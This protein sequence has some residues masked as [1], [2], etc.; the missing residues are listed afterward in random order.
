MCRSED[1]LFTAVV[2]SCPCKPLQTPQTTYLPVPRSTRASFRNFF[3]SFSAN[4]HELCDRRF[5]SQCSLPA[6]HCHATRIRIGNPRTYAHPAC[7]VGCRKRLPK[8]AA[9]VIVY[10]RTRRERDPAT[11]A[12]LQGAPNT[13]LTLAVSSPLTHRPSRLALP[14]HWGRKQ[15]S[16]ITLG[17]NDRASVS[18]PRPCCTG[19]LDLWPG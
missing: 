4:S 15:R 14:A 12:I 7:S 2:I 10:L 8:A 13:R 19:L 3:M 18:L 6:S 5:S 9:P 1:I 17:S 16:D 11:I